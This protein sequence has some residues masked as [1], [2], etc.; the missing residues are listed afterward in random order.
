MCD[1][2]NANRIVEIDYITRQFERVFAHRTYEI[3]VHYIDENEII[4]VHVRR[5]MHVR[6]CV[7][8]MQI[9]CD[10]E[11]YEF[12]D[13]TLNDDREYRE[14]VVFDIMTNDDDTINNVAYVNAFARMIELR[15]LLTRT[16]N[17]RVMND[18]RYD[19]LSN[20]IENVQSRIL[21]AYEFN[22]DDDE[23]RIV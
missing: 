16:I 20:M 11:R 13:V 6:D 19:E 2:M 12:I 23:Y 14:R 10:D 5:D 15:D 1:D 18:A 22:V 8:E 3:D 7:F 4:V 9:T 21:N 17:D